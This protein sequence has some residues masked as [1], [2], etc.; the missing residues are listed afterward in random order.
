MNRARAIMSAACVM[1]M[2][3]LVLGTETENHGIR[4]LPAP[5]RVVVDGSAGDWDLTGGVF[6]CGDVEN[7]R[8]KIACWFHAMYD[9]DSLY[10]LSRWIDHTPLNNPGTVKADYGFSGDCLQVR[11]ITAPDEGARERTAHLTAWR[12]RDGTDLIDV[13]YGKKFNEGSM[14]DAQKKGAVQEFSKHKSGKGYVQEISMPW[15]LLA[16]GGYRPKAGETVVITVEPNF[17]IGRRWRMTI[18]GIF[19]AGST[20]SRTFTFM[21]SPS[22]G[23]GV[24]AA[25]GGVEP[26]P[27]R[28][29]DAR[30][31]AVRMEDG[32]PVV[33]WTGLMARK[34]LKGFLPLAFT[35]PGDGYISLH[36]RNEDGQVVRQLLNCAFMTKGDHEVEW[37][38]LATPGFRR[39]GRPVPPGGYTWRGIWHT[40]IGLRFRG[41]ASNGGNPPW[42]DPSGKGDW[43][44]DHGFPI[45]CASDDTKVYLGWSGA[46]AGKALVACDGARVL[47]RWNQSLPSTNVVKWCYQRTCVI[48]PGFQQATN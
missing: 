10:F 21:D 12:D 29:S 14:K 27:V 42:D 20:P 44:G 48:V 3:G 32:A 40:G 37:D 4:I 46:E 26:R 1:T 41:W 15:K 6:I 7:L 31:F 16:K 19:R 2:A 38:G 18:K 22:W 11:V 23:R 8:D 43:G 17:T 5:G 25:K 33:D 45:A 13:S 28:L 30:E 47:S 24:L 9:E 39:P 34:E 35:M 36:I